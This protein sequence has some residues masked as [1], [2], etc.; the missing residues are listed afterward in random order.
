VAPKKTAPVMHV[1]LLR[2]INVGKAKRI[3]MADLRELCA[4]LGYGNVRTLLNS[5]N[6]VFSAP[7]ADAKA[8]AKIEKAIEAEHG[9]SSRVVVVTASVLDEIVEE[10]PFEEAESNPSRFLVTVLYDHADRARLA[11]L[12]KQDWG[13]E[14]LALGTHAVYSWCADGILESA[15]LIALNKA[16][17]DAGTNRNWATIKKIQAMMAT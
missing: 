7:R 16:L 2:G 12:A 13:P 10:N 6:V 17:G 11:A 3:A 1:A 8:A 9:F 5:G 14:R 4:S 15:S